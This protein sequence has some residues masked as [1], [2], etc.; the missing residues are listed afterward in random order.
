MHVAAA[1]LLTA[2]GVIAYRAIGEAAQKRAVTAAFGLHVSPDV[3]MELLKREGGAVDALA[4]KRAKV[5][6]FYSDIR[7][8]TAM[9]EK[10][11]PEAVYEQL[12]E[13][14]EAMCEVIFKYGG[15]VDKFIGDCIMAVFSSMM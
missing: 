15:Y 14:F 8:F 12:N 4:G 13:Y 2:L 5:T 10:L 9:S 6:I 11:P 7:G 1:M 3:V